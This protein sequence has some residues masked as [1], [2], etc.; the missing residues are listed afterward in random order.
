MLYSLDTDHVVKQQPSPKKEF[1]LNNYFSS[2]LKME[3]SD[4]IKTSVTMYET[5]A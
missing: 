5:M 3:A 2:T 1:Y 4:S